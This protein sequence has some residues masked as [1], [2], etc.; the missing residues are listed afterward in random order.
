MPYKETI[1]TIERTLVSVAALA[2]LLPIWQF[3]TETR[4]REL[5]RVANFVLAYRACFG[6]DGVAIEDERLEELTEEVNQHLAQVAEEVRS[7]ETIDREHSLAE[8]ISFASELRRNF[9]RI[10]Q[11]MAQS[12]SR[13]DQ[14]YRQES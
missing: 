12:C 1:A 2:A 3:A 10:S 5:D 7:G 11:T 4:D 13:L 6:E 14:L 8:T 9:E